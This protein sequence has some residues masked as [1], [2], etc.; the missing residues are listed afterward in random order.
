LPQL[1]GKITCCLP[2]TVVVVVVPDVLIVVV[3]GCCLCFYTICAAN[4]LLRP[5]WYFEK[6][7]KNACQDVRHFNVCVCVWACACVCV[8]GVCVCVSAIKQARKGVKATRCTYAKSRTIFALHVPNKHTQRPYSESHK[9]ADSNRSKTKIRTI[10]CCHSQH[11][12]VCACRCITLIYVHMHLVL[13]YDRE[14]E[15]GGKIKNKGLETY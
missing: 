12:C 13:G 15:R 1:R 10:K 5:L 14:R 2:Q 8:L 11:V 3:G 9:K 4:S 6:L 7:K